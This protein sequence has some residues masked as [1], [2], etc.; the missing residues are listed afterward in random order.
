MI[1]CKSSVQSNKRYNSDIFAH[2]VIT[3]YYHRLYFFNGFYS[4]EVILYRN[5]PLV[6]AFCNYCYEIFHC[7]S[8]WMRRAMR[9]TE[10]HT[11]L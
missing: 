8:V 1:S 11:D 6:R 2:S 5:K 9:A 3:A 4:F 7:I 10:D